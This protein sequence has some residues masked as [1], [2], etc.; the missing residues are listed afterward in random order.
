M[1]LKLETIFGAK[2]PESSRLKRR[3][4]I[5]L[6]SA[7]N[8]KASICEGLGGGTIGNVETKNFPHYKASALTW[9][10]IYKFG[11]ANAAI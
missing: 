1:E 4:T 11:A 10:N 8:Y 2:E 5:W 3:A 9:N 6:V 7:Q